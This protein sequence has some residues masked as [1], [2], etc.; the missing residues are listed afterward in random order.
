MDLDLIKKLSK[1]FG[2]DPSGRDEATRFISTGSQLLDIAIANRVDGGIPIG[3]LTEIVGTES[4]GKSVLMATLIANAQKQGMKCFL[5]DT[6][7]TSDKYFLTKFGVDYEDL[8][9]LVLENVED[10]MTAI[11]YIIKK[12]QDEVIAQEP[13]K[14]KKNNRKELFIGWD[15]VAITPSKE[16]VENDIEK[17]SMGQIPRILSK[18]LRKINKLVSQTNTTLVFANQ[19]KENIGQMFGDKM[20]APGGRA[21]KYHASTRIRLD[22]KT[23]IKNTQEQ[24]IGIKVKAKVIKNKVSIPYRE[25]NFDIVFNRGIS[26][27]DY[28]LD[29]LGKGKVVDLG[30]WNKITLPGKPESKFRRANWPDM[31][32]SKEF[33]PYIKEQIEKIMILD[34]NFIPATEV[35]E[36]SEENP[37]TDE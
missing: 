23:E 17:Q 28:W 5:I 19:L 32:Q 36:D 27:Y 9:R 18:G 31:C 33:G 30:A 29:I 4:A 10:V 8:T 16:E 3:R 25:A 12:Y 13:A 21:I 34:E 2:Y 11:E 20:V 1:D 7:T 22:K 35:T 15:S 14:G 24:S 6:E 26:D 37:S